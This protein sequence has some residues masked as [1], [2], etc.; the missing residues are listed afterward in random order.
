MFYEKRILDR[1]LILCEDDDLKAK[2]YYDSYQIDSLTGTIRATLEKY[3]EEYE[4]WVE[5]IVCIINLD[6]FMKPYRVETKTT[7]W[8]GETK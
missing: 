4:F 2:Y 5:Q 6:I 3:S 7:P 8:F 1:L